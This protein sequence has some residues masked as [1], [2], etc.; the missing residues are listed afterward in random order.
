M[1]KR[2]LAIMACWIVIASPAVAGDRLTGV[3]VVGSDLLVHT[4]DGG[5]IR[6]E[7]L[8]GAE[9]AMMLNGRSALTVRIDAV[10]PDPKA[11][12]DDVVIY[13]LSMR[14]ASGAWRPVCEP[15]PYGERHAIL[16]P[17]PNGTLDIWCTDGTY[18]KC[19]RFGYRPWAT[20]PN[21]E[22]LAPYH[23][24][25]AKMLRADYCGNDQPTTRNGMWVELYDSLDFQTPRFETPEMTFEAAWNEEGAVCVAHPR[26]PQNIDLDRLAETCPRLRGRLGKVCTAASAVNFGKP[27]IFNGSRGDGITEAERQK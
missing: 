21:G 11:M 9:M 8:V 17:T 27:L 23:M 3:E 4:G 6:G 10:A 7:A 20:G 24:A 13:D 22:S 1:M 15:D 14:E 19:V 18:A 5:T 25:C 12:T 2:T 26:V 16:Q